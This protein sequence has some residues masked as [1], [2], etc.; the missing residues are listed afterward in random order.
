MRKSARR[1]TQFKWIGIEHAEYT[2]KASDQEFMCIQYCTIEFVCL[3]IYC[4]CCHCCVTKII[5]TAQHR[6]AEKRKARPFADF[7]LFCWYFCLFVWFS[8]PTY[9]CVYLCKK[10]DEQLLVD[11]SRETL[12]YTKG[13]CCRAFFFSFLRLAFAN[14]DCFAVCV[15]ILNI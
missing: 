3:L 15:V 5:K 4:C 1:W 11:V 7:C 10:E 6:P 9:S 13:N 14:P 12:K 8:T 2:R